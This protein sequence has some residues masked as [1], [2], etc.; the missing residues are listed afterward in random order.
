MDVQFDINFS[1]GFNF[2]GDCGYL[3]RHW[4]IRACICPRILPV[5]LAL[6]VFGKDV[7]IDD[8]EF[9]LLFV[10]VAWSR[11]MEIGWIIEGDPIIE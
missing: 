1:I 7:I 10:D 8:D 3:I 11:I 4:I 2:D 6:M 5:K 9:D